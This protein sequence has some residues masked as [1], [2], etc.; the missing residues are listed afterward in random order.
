[1]KV[2]KVRPL[3][4]D[5]QGVLKKGGTVLIVENLSQLQDEIEEEDVGTEYSIEII[6]MSRERLGNL[7]EFEGF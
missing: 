6:N 2:W 4:F 5:K 1:M 3:Y 7:P